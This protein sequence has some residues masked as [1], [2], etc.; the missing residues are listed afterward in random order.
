VDFSCAIRVCAHLFPYDISL[1]LGPAGMCSRPVGRV[2]DGIIPGMDQGSTNLASL[3]RKRYALVVELC[4]RP[5]GRV[6]DG[7]RTRNSQ[8]HNLELYH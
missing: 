4:S 5:V 1:R 7:T 8:N 6:T 2:T 3:K